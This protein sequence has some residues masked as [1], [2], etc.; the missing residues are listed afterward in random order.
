MDGQQVPGQIVF[1]NKA[2]CRDCLRCLRNCPVKAIAM[3][4]G[5][6]FVVQERCIACGTCIRE[7]PQ[8]A[9]SFRNDVERASRLLA[10]G[11]PVA[12]SV[13]PSF[14]AVFP[15]WQRRR[16]PS[17]LRKLGF[18]YIAETA[19]GAY[20]V[21][22]RSMELA[23]QREGEPHICT[24]CPA[25]VRL[26]ELYRPQLVSAMLPVAS[27]ML[28]HA[29]LIKKSRGAE[30]RVVFI[31]P[32]VAKKA[33]AEKPQS[34]S[35]VDCVLTFE[36]L[37]E[38]LGREGI[39]LAGCEE[40]DFDE[41]PQGDA[42]LFPVPGGLG[43]TAALQC[44]YLE[45]GFSVVSGF[46]E[47][48]SALD[49]LTHNPR[50][51]TL[52]PLF[53]SLGCVNGP[54]IGKVSDT[55]YDRRDEVL[56]YAASHPGAED[57]AGQSDLDL[58]VRFSLQGGDL[59]KEFP[60]EE[61]R[62]V[63][64]RT[65]KA[66]EEDQ[67][68]CGACGYPTCREKAIA[69]LRGMAEI[70]MC[71]PY[72]RRLAEQRSDRIIETSPNG[73]VVLDKQLKII[74]MNPAFRNLFQCSEAVCG[75]NISYLMD[76]AL[77]EK[78]AFEGENLIERRVRHA[79]YNLL[80]HEIIYALREEEQFIG[81]FV[82]ITRGETDKQKL[83]QLGADTIAQARELVHQQ[84]DMAQKMA[85]LLGQNTAQGEALVRNLLNLASEDTGEQGSRWLWDIYTSK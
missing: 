68:N 60:E 13:A 56:A 26:I 35:L 19:I 41:S 70:E 6:A 23:R 1:T 25:V 55:P 4:D 7:C 37:F 36:E 44:G 51:M 33:E 77:F 66:Q 47:I 76:P 12:A 75:K 83:E 15:E 85:Q 28:A 64:E 65:G 17:A 34:G 21:A 18:S 22:R 52:E 2:R 50:P 80:C 29:Q 31:G 53:C 42:R 81:I 45:T 24:A 11:G 20:Y 46:A 30:S 10:G 8:K 67:L 57:R 14:A 69:V 58:S 62:R 61:I 79:S 63:L 59:F 72:M 27:P 9:K 16:L 74:K 5:Q 82:N 71:I 78:V 39:D 3:R 48:D 84:V 32:C 43:K 73:I 40:S 54:A 38:W 49:S